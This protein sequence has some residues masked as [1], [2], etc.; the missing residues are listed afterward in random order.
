LLI[1]AAYSAFLSIP[2]ELVVDWRCSQSGKKA[3][4][5]IQGRIKVFE[6]S[7]VIIADGVA[8]FSE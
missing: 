7:T 3:A 1:A 5:G 6:G 2:L 4:T 8:E